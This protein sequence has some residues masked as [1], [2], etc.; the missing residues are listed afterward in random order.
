MI[1]TNRELRFD[2]LRVLKNDEGFNDDR[3]DGEGTE[4][5]SDDDEDGKADRRVEAER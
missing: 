2:F 4:N 5:E 1:S 3:N